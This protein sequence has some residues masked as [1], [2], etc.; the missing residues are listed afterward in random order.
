VALEAN[1]EEIERGNGLYWCAAA[2]PIAAIDSEVLALQQQTALAEY[3]ARSRLG[4]WSRDQ[5]AVFLLGMS[6]RASQ[7]LAAGELPESACAAWKEVRLRAERAT[8]DI[9]RP[10]IWW[11][12]WSRAEAWSE[13]VTDWMDDALPM[14][15][16]AQ[17]ADEPSLEG[18]SPCAEAL[19]PRVAVAEAARVSGAN[20]TKV[21][22]FL[23]DL[24]DYAYGRDLE[25]AGWTAEE[26]EA[27]PKEPH[28]IARHFVG[29]G[30]RR[31]KGKSPA[32]VLRARLTENIEAQTVA[33]YYSKGLALRR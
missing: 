7:R 24:M 32:G 5:A 21:F 10:P 14:I 27:A 30:G 6:E 29:R 25:A 19:A 11:V 16:L 23:A 18:L 2:A 4:T 3:V 17:V 15:V 31:K 28:R 13:C 8:D 26:I 12:A 22:A 20:T 1:D 33:I 9:S